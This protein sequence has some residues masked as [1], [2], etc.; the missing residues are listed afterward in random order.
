MKSSSCVFLFS[1]CSADLE[2][3]DYFTYI[4]VHYIII[5]DDVTVVFLSDSTPLYKDSVL[6]HMPAFCLLV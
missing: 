3:H 5:H 6:S 4:N 2:K 1:V